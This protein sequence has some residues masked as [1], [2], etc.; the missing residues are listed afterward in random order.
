MATRE[1]MTREVTCDR[2]PAVL[3]VL[4]PGETHEPG[5]VLLSLGG[6]LAPAVEWRDLCESCQTALADPIRRVLRQP[7]P[8]KAAE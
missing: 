1:T 7:T 3:R 5:P 6:S 2:C 4:E 8:K